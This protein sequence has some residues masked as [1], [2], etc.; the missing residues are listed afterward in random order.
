MGRGTILSA[1]GMVQTRNSGTRYHSFDD[2]HGA[3][4]QQW[5]EVPSFRR[6]A[7]ANAQQWDEVPFFRRLAGIGAQ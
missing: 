7:G 5:D 3:D 6:L 2:W 1:I 4:A